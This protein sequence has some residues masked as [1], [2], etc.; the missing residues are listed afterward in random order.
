MATAR[1][2]QRPARPA[3]GRPAK[4]SFTIA[5]HRTS[6]SL[7]EP[8]WL[9]LGEIAESRCLPVAAIV[10][11]IDRGRGGAGLSGAIRVHVLRHFRDRAAKEL[12]SVA[13]QPF[14]PLR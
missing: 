2:P 3:S 14:E 11:A 1:P 4:R 5:G 7:E 6:V 13:E 12:E 8:F 9:A 10:E